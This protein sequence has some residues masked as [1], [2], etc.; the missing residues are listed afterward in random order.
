M[1]VW[2]IT[3]CLTLAVLLAEAQKV[4]ESSRPAAGVET[5]S[6]SF[7]VGEHLEEASQD[8]SQMFFFWVRDSG[9]YNDNLD[10]W[11]AG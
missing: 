4:Q 10:A 6:N 11:A 8:L 7:P 2:N 1:E 3:T 9:H 5:G